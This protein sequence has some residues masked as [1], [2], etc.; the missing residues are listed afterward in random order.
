MPKT[1]DILL[2]NII[3]R[4]F[5]ALRLSTLANVSAMKKKPVMS[6]SHVFVGDVSLQFQLNLQW[7][8]GGAWHKSHAMSYA[9]D[10]SVNG[11]GCSSESY[12]LHNIRRLSADTWQLYQ[13]LELGWHFP[14]ILLMD[15]PCRLNYVLRLG[16]RIRHAA[17]IRKD[18]LRLYFSHGFRIGKSGE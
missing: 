7:S 10:M 5:L 11:H 15:N 17:D 4:A 12:R 1:S 6:V 8:I 16:I 13:I 3:E 2:A 14:A 9:E 18:V